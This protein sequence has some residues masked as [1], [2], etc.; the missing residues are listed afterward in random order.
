MGQCELLPWG[1][2]PSASLT[3]SLHL[4]APGGLAE[5]IVLDEQAVLVIETGC[6]CLLPHLFSSQLLGPGVSQTP[7]D[8]HLG[9]PC[10]L[11]NLWERAGASTTHERED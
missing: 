1:S 10:C 9:E 6:T 7:L 2:H 11:T 4:F 8:I 3:T 5:L